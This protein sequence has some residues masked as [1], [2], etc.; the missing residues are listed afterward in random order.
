MYFTLLQMFVQIEYLNWSQISQRRYCILCKNTHT[1]QCSYHWSCPIIKW[2]GHDLYSIQTL[3][4]LVFIC[5]PGIRVS[6]IH[7]T[8]VFRFR[9][10]RCRLFVRVKRRSESFYRSQR[11]RFWSRRGHGDGHDD[12]DDGSHSAVQMW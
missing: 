5:F 11:R 6:I 12:P 8:T 10:N 2:S 3:K 1:E 9:N 7:V 4:S